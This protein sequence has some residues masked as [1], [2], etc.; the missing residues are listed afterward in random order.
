MTNRED[1]EI[2]GIGRDLNGKVVSVFV[3]RFPNHYEPLLAQCIAILKGLL[4]DKSHGL[5]IYEVESD[6]IVAI[7]TIN[8]S[9]VSILLD[10]IISD[11]R[12]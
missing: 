1:V 11:V 10:S 2:G 4:L 7:Q 12:K 8:N 3:K 5:Q 6:S 9:S